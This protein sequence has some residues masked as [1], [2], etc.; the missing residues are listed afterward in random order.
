[1]EIN[2]PLFTLVSDRSLDIFLEI[3]EKLSGQVSRGRT[4][5]LFARAIPDWQRQTLITAVIPAADSTSRRQLVRVTLDNPPSE[6]LPGMAIQA[7]L[8]IPVNSAD[9]FMV[10]RDALT[11]RGNKWLLFTVKDNQAQQLEVE[12]VSDLGAEVVVSNPQLRKGQSVVI[13]GGDGLRPNSPVK[14]VSN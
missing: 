4:V 7:D 12:I 10:P 9:G 11:R 8:E 13:K 2:D 6:L 14:V 5:N 1:V 3:P